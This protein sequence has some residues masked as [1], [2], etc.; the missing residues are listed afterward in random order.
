VA[1]LLVACNVYMEPISSIVQQLFCYLKFASLPSTWRN[2]C[3]QLCT[4]EHMHGT[5]RAAAAVQSTTVTDCTAFSS[6]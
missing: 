1:A 2:H 3:L 4:P 6:T 5:S